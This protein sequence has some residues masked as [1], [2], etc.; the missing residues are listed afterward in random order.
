MRWIMNIV[1]PMLLSA[2]AVAKTSMDGWPFS[3]KAKSY[4]DL[5][6]YPG[7]DR[8]VRFVYPAVTVEHPY[9][10]GPPGHRR[11][12]QRQAQRPDAGP[13]IYP[14]GKWTLRRIKATAQ[15]IFAYTVPIARP[16]RRGIF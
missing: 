10:T 15:R 16:Y 9:R 3:L 2:P 8:A 13:I 12:D 11:D 4:R 7:D 14:Q 5:V 1:I 6:V